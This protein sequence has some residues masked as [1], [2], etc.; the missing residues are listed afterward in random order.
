VGTFAIFLLLRAGSLQIWHV[1]AVAAVASVFN[2]FQWPAYLAA[3]TVLVPKRHLG[4][5][6]GMLQFGQASAEVVAPIL[7]GLLIS[8]VGMHGVVAIDLGTFLFAA[9]ALTLVRIPRPAASGAGRKG[10]LLTEAAYG[11]TFIRERP[12]LLGLLLYFAVINTVS[13]IA[14]VLAT[15]LVLSFTTPKVLGSILAASSCGLVA[16][17]VVMTVTGGPRPRIH[18]VLGF[19]CLFGAA[20][21]VAGW[22]PSPVLIGVGLFL[23]MFGGPIIN[24]SSQA[25]W[26]V[27]VPPDVQ[28]R[29]FA[30]RRL[31]AQFTVPLG[32]FCAGP[33]ADYVFRPLLVEGGP[34]AGSAGRI[35]GVGP[36][37]GIGLI[38]ICLS[39]LPL[40]ASLWAY[41][42][43]RV[44]RVEEELPDAVAA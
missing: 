2:S 36:G 4:R 9:A 28:G 34:L 40:L 3:T 26:Q 19:G 44:R 7:A 11:W 33:L 17:S 39:V 12:G 30:V 31:I 41:T 24:G 25:I 18:G 35:L 10:S 13:S 27:K 38:F 23:E 29:V 1:Y 22:R 6:N 42:R 5:A 43:P 32:F 21:A 37:R 16:G 20:L 14:A 15:P 8:L